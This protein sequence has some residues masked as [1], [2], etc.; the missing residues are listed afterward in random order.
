MTTKGRQGR[1]RK[2]TTRIRIDWKMSRI[3]DDTTP[4]NM[5]RATPQDLYCNRTDQIIR[6]QVQKQ[7]PKRSNF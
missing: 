6:A 2:K 3:E 1:Y 5:D 7:A 4:L